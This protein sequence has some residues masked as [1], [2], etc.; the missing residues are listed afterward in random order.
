VAEII[1]LGEKLK[2]VQKKK[3]TLLRRRKL[4]TLEAFFQGNSVCERC[5]SDI[6]KQ[7]A[8]RDIRVPYLF[9]DVCAQEYISYIERLQGKENPE[10]YWQNFSWMDVWRRWIDYRGAT[11]QYIQSKEFLQ[12]REETDLP[13]IG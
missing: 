1:S 12:L 4:M 8:H 2:D 6:S 7:H 5:H 11:D 10:F 13:D 3:E 9:C